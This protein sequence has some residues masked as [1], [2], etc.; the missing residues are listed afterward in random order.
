MVLVQALLRPRELH[1]VL[2][3]DVPGQ[4][5]AGVQIRADHRAL[6]AAEGLLGKARDLLQK[7]LLRVLGQ[8]ERTDLFAVFGKFLRA[9]LV[10]L[11]ELAA[12]Q[13]HL[14]AQVEVAL[15]AL[16]LLLRRVVQVLFQRQDRDLAAEHAVEQLK[17]LFRAQLL[18]HELLFRVAQRAV[19]GDEI[20]EDAEIVGIGGGQ[21]HLRRDDAGGG[22]VFLIE[23]QAAAQKRLKR[24][25]RRRALP[26]RDAL[27]VRRV[28]RRGLVDLQRFGAVQSLHHDLDHA[29]ARDAED[30]TDRADRP[31]RVELRFGGHLGRDVSLRDQKDLLVR[32]QRGV[33]RGDGQWALH[34][35]VQDRPGKCGQP[36]QRQDRHCENQVVFFHRIPRFLLCMRCVLSRGAS[37]A[38]SRSGCSR[39]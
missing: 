12:D 28:A 7:L 13:L 5:Q 24:R 19:L 38:P 8:M 4:L 6:A 32:S 23:G 2:R 22:G 9:D 33:Q 3:A 17:A 37:R 26:R 31:H 36:A 18:Q 21:E 1:V 11:A 14:L 30:L 39:R 29:A 27:H 35:K 34:V 10:A 25:R 15:G 20:G 16:H